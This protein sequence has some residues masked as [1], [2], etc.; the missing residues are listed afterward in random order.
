M[1][2][3]PSVETLREVLDAFNR[4]DLDTIMEFF[5]DECSMDMPRGPNAYGNRFIS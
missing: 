2:E 3:S 1:P 4:H 5:A